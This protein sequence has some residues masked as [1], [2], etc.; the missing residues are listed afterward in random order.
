MIKKFFV[1]LVFFTAFVLSYGETYY[2]PHL[3]TADTTW[4]N[5]IIIDNLTENTQTV[6]IKLYDNT[7]AVSYTNAISVNGN[8]VVTITLAPTDGALGYVDTPSSSVRVRLGFI[9]SEA[10]GGGTAEFDLENKLYNKLAL[11]MSNYYDQLTWSGFAILNGTNE[12]VEVT[13]SFYNATGK[14]TGDVDFQLPA[15]SKA[16]S[17][18]DGAFGI[19]FKNTQY[20]IFSTENDSLAS[21]IISGKNNEKLLFTKAKPVKEQWNFSEAMTLDNSESDVTGVIFDGT[22]LYQVGYIGDWETSNGFLNI[23]DPNNGERLSNI[24]ND[25]VGI[26]ITGISLSCDGSYAIMTGFKNG[27]YWICTINLGSGSIIWQKEIADLPQDDFYRKLQAA[28]SDST[29]MIQYRTADT[30]YCIQKLF[31]SATGSETA[32]VEYSVDSIPTVLIC[33]DNSYYSIK[34]D[35]DSTSNKYI[36]VIFMD[37][38]KDSLTVHSVTYQLGSEYVEGCFN[39]V[40]AGGGYFKDGYL[41][42]MLKFG[43]GD[44]WNMMA[45][46]LETMPAEVSVAAYD[47]QA[48][49]LRRSATNATCDLGGKDSIT[50]N[51]K[52]KVIGFAVSK[53]WPMFETKLFDFFWTDS[54]TPYFVGTTDVFTLNFLVNDVTFANGKLFLDY[55]KRKYDRNALAQ[56]KAVFAKDS[57]S[58]YLI[59]LGLLGISYE[60]LL[61][62]IHGFYLG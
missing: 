45:Y 57:V 2:I 16:V 10:S 39:H 49:H 43:V 52:G 51:S 42:C 23:Y 55:N 34:S 22:K 28:G 47:A 5:Y 12:E 41:Y 26:K 32:S 3:H 21:I 31:N 11:S 59:V 20:V 1:A 46:R 38:S 50:E 60:E 29:V 48:N 14:M 37:N 13:A 54:S 62:L 9:A 25:F 24:T 33:N 4:T 56:A 30:G 6:T 17:T 53:G 58:D 27:K 15:N 35:L 36:N 18:F 19:D 40:L 44:D 8:D 61:N 7:G